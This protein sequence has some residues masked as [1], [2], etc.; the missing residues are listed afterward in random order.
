[1]GLYICVDIGIHMYMSS[2]SHQRNNFFWSIQHI[3]EARIIRSERFMTLH[4]M[5]HTC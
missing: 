5:Y 4:S 2:K 1:M 3:I